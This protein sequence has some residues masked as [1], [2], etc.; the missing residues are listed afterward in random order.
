MT[1]SARASLGSRSSF[2]VGARERGACGPRTCQWASQPRARKKCWVFSTLK[3]NVIVHG[4]TRG[5][6]PLKSGPRQR[7]QLPQ[8]YWTLLQML[9]GK[10]KR[11]R[12]G[13]NCQS[14]SELGQWGGRG[15]D[16]TESPW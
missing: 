14:V 15:E 11:W 8:H 10:W 4:E 9:T 16:S 2:E 1:R 12:V 6:A 5:K 3:L 13:G 7:Y